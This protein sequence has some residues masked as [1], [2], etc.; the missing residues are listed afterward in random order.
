MSY[1]PFSSPCLFG[2]KPLPEQSPYL[3]QNMLFHMKALGKDRKPSRRQSV[4]LSQPAVRKTARAKPEALRPFPRIQIQPWD[5]GEPRKAVDASPPES[6][7]P[8][9]KVLTQGELEGLLN[10]LAPKLPSKEAV[11]AVVPAKPGF[12]IRNIDERIYRG[13]LKKDTLKKAVNSKADYCQARDIPASSNLFWFDSPDRHVA[14]ELA[15]RGWHQIESA[16]DR[17]F[18]DLLYVAEDSPL[19]HQGL[20]DRQILNHFA[21]TECLTSKN[22]FHTLMGTTPGS[23]QFYCESFRG[24]NELEI[25]A[26]RN[27]FFLDSSFKIL[28]LHV[29][30]FRDREPEKTRLFSLG[31]RHRPSPNSD[32]Q[33]FYDLFPSKV[34]K[35]HAQL[36]P[37]FQ[38]NLLLIEQLL[39]VW[40]SVVDQIDGVSEDFRYRDFAKFDASTVQVLESVAKMGPRFFEEDGSRQETLPPEFG[41]FWKTPSDYLIYKIVHFWTFLEATGARVH[42]QCSGRNTWI[43]KPG[44]K[45]KGAGMVLSQSLPDI[46]DRLQENG[47][48]VIQRYV[49]QPL[50]LPGRTKFDMRIWVLLTSVAPLQAFYFSEFYLRFC[51][52]EYSETDLSPQSHLTNF[53]LNKEYFGDWSRSVGSSAAFAQL[54]NQSMGIDFQRQVLPR[55]ERVL[56]TIFWNAKENLGHREKSFEVFGVDVLLD[57]DCQ[58]WVLEVNKS[59]ACQERAQF[60][61]QNLKSMAQGLVSWVEEG[62]LPRTAQGQ[63]VPLVQE[64]APPKEER[65]K[66][67]AVLTADILSG[68][69]QVDRVDPL[70]E[71][72]HELALK[73]HFC[74]LKITSLVRKAANKRKTG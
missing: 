30:F 66:R 37:N 54:L 22:G 70:K 32:F 57:A 69:L 62:T 53:S 31:C 51:P 36:R 26:F 45:S 15:R 42:R 43:L 46:L 20:D 41:E 6:V 73:R 3:R 28:K 61:A 65:G 49:E 47:D 29:D 60:L 44:A 13:L 1:Q 38:I 55:I 10:R 40:E 9:E 33:F 68:V 21:H 63:W 12:K 39:P 2:P 35:H 4:T 74:A 72:E 59:P 58:P 24:G 25:R 50:L 27:R 48:R 34:R 67:E 5:R 7:R 19:L 71:R 11:E 23:N 52:A 16:S 56:R 17:R 64:E 8:P 14:V 18:A